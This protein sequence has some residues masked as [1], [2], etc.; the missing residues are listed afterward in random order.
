MGGRGM[1]ELPWVSLVRCLVESAFREVCLQS[2][3][4]TACNVIKHPEASSS[5]P[6]SLRS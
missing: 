1:P 6:P 3:E 5:F 2:G 4:N